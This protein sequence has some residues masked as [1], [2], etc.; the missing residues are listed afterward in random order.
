MKGKAVSAASSSTARRA[1]ED[2]RDHQLTGHVLSA[3]RSDLAALQAEE[4]QRTGVYLLL[5]DD[6]GG[7]DTRCYIG[8]A[9]DIATRLRQH[10]NDPN[11]AFW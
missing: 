5:G 3:P 11:K 9:D 7:G 10:A 2:R 6:D 4:V 1:A 8:E